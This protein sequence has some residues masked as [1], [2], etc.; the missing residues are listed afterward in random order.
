M[1]EVFLRDS[2]VTLLFFG[3]TRVVCSSCKSLAVHNSGLRKPLLV[4]NAYTVH[5]LPGSMS[6]HI[7]AII[8]NH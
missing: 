4:M 1:V 5:S 2:I 8:L 3:C 7:N 6:R